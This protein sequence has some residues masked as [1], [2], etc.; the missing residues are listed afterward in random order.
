[1]LAAFFYHVVIYPLSLLPFSVLYKLSDIIFILLYYV[2]GYRR[3]VVFKNLCNSFPQLSTDEL[4][5]IQKNYYRHLSDLVVESIKLF[6]ISEAE[7]KR[8]MVFINSSFLDS[9][10][11]RGQNLILAGGHLN[12]WELF[13]VAIAQE[14]KHEPIGIYQPFTSAYFDK[15]MKKSRSKFGLK[16]VSTKIVKETFEESGSKPTITIFG[17]DQAPSKR[18]KCHTMQFL[19]QETRVLFGAE[20]YAKE[21]NYHVVYGR[22]NK[23]KR[24][25][26][27][28]EFLDVI[29]NPASTTHGEITERINRLIERDII[30]SP[31]WL[32]SHRRWKHKASV[33]KKA[34]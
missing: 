12:N 32:W 28:F 17:V 15:L 18:S 26:Y 21:Y 31:A 27:S 22:I 8:R 23:I 13:A 24:G 7:I 4:Q 6:S 10:F 30:A 16:M 29:E 14:I 2:I 20:K 33:L 34:A 9:Y 5:K 19:N 3:K 25:Y 1:M 11:S